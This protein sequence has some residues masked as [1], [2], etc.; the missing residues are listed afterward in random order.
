MVNINWHKFSIW[1]FNITSRFPDGVPHI[2]KRIT[3]KFIFCDANV[4]LSVKNTINT[5]GLNAKLFTVN[6]TIDGFDSI[7]SLMC[8]TGDEE[9]FVYAAKKFICKENQNI[10]STFSFFRF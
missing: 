10:H 6:G 1:H 2:L 5:I 9:N 4:L 7:D 3:P 8:A